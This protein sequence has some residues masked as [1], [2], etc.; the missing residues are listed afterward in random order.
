MREL[1]ASTGTWTAGGSRLELVFTADP[2]GGCLVAWPDGRWMGRAY[3]EPSGLTRVTALAGR[4][5]GV[6]DWQTVQTVVETNK[7]SL[8]WGGR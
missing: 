6:V 7:A 5:L 8:P 2:N 1:K 4:E 3:L